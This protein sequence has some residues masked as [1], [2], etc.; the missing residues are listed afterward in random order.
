MNN[1]ER[2]YSHTHCW[3]N[4]QKNLGGVPPCGIKVEKHTQ[5]CLCDL[6]YD[7]V[8]EKEFEPEEFIDHLK[9]GI[10]ELFEALDHYKEAM[11]NLGKANVL[12]TKLLK[13][14]NK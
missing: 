2:N 4:E 11:D 3:N 14:Q 5:C 7:T 6:K 13:H 1:Y 9:K 10:P 12:L 8:K